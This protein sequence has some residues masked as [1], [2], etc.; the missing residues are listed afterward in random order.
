[1]FFAHLAL[2]FSAQFAFAAA[3]FFLKKQSR[4]GNVLLGMVM[5]VLSF[6][7]FMHYMW[8]SRNVYH[9]TWLLNIDV[10]LDGCIGPLLYFYLLAMT[11]QLRF[12]PAM[13]LHFWPLLPGAV[14]YVYFNTQPAAF[15]IDFIN[16]VYTAVPLAA[17]IVNVLIAG[18]LAAGYRALDAYIKKQNDTEWVSGYS[19]LL[20]L[21]QFV[22]ILFAINIAAAPLN[23]I[24]RFD[25]M[26]I[27]FPAITAFVIIFVI[28]KTFNHPEVMTTEQVRKITRQLQYQKEIEKVR[29]QISQDIHDELGA[30]LTQI[31]MMS[32]LGKIQHRTDTILTTQFSQV[33][34][35]SQNLMAS[36]REV[37]WAINPAHDNVTSLQ[38]FLRS[39]I[40]NF[41]DATDIQVEID[42]A[43]PNTEIRLS[44][45]IHRSIILVVKEAANN[46]AKHA[47]ATKAVFSCSADTKGLTLHIT[48]NGVGIPATEN[49]TGNGIKNMHKRIAALG[50]TI[51]IAGNSGTGT[52]IKIW[53][54]L[55]G[56]A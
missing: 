53:C 7:H 16:Q 15:K 12:K 14:W 30:G 39:F 48:D 9:Y 27:G 50:G 32:E 49:A 25:Y 52:V 36:L 18:Y 17:T 37:V 1:M 26:F 51:S 22:A 20:W 4:T 38:V 24:A 47:K 33:A 43:E 56:I 6:Q 46:L 55:T 10:P 8:A 3:L 2:I 35:V 29:S 34:Q 11:G 45:S 42:F 5:L 31:S 54:P 13:L 40:G 41:F 44:P 23:L 28:Y 21:R 19:N